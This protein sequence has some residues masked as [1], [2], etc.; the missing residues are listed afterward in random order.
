MYTGHQAP[1]N[2]T[3]GGIPRNVPFPYP[4][5][6][7]YVARVRYMRSMIQ[8]VMDDVRAGHVV[9]G[10]DVGDADDQRWLQRHWMRHPTEVAIDVYVIFS[11]NIVTFNHIQYGHG[12]FPDHD[13]CRRRR[14][15][16]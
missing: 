12:C 3:Q 4:N 2:A 1:P 16:C 5:S 10:E 7:G 6:G 15:H 14:R 9:A 11:C 13:R 8:E